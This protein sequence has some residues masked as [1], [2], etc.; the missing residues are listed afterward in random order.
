MP[1]L[2]TSRHLQSQKTIKNPSRRFA[3][4]GRP[5]LIR[6]I[7]RQAGLGEATVDRVLNNRG[8]VRRG[9]PRQVQQGI[10]DLR[11]GSGRGSGGGPR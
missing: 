2:L 7:A 11:T 8:S 9:T 3:L 6:E 1:F 4:M 10:A 5:Y